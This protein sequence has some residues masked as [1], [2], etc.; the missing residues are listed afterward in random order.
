MLHTFYAKS[1][2]V[3][4]SLGEGKVWLRFFTFGDESS[5]QT[6]FMLDPEEAFRSHLG[7]VSVVK[8]GNKFSLTHKFNEKQSILT[9]E[10]WE[11]ENKSGFGVIIKKDEIKINVPLDQANVLFLAELLKAM[12]IESTKTITTQKTQAET[13]TEEVTVET[14]TVLPDPDETSVQSQTETRNGSSKIQNAKIEAVRVDG[15]A[16]KVNGQWYEI[17]DKTKIEGGS[18]GKGKTINLYYLKGERKNF[19][20]AIYIVAE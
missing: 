7:V 1:T 10:K 19:A 3:E 14:K 11:R 16:F 15:K 6:K 18:I 5:K 2:G 20:N 13:Q 8:N 17:T 4:V 9:I 12:A